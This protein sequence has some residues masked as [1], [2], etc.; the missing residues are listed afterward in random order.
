MTEHKRTLLAILAHPD[1][2]SF[3]MGATIAK[4]A[5]EGVAVHYLC[6]T[7]GASGTV[8]A[9]FLEKFDSIA[10]LRHHE[11]QC[12]AQELG[13][14]SVIMGGYRD[15]GMPGTEANA[16][17]DALINQPLDDVAAHFASE[18]RRLRPDV[19]VTHDPI[20]GY[21][22]PDHIACNKATLRAFEIVN[23]SDARVPGDLPPFQPKKLY[24]STISKTW[25]KFGITV[26]RLLGKDP[27]KFGRNGDIDILDL[28]ESGDFP[29]HAFIKS[30]PFAAQQEAAS[31]CHASQL[32]SGIPRKGPIALF[33][34]LMRGTSD[35]YMRAIPEAQNGLRENDFFEGI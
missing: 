2:E 9:P 31:L 8:D 34:R 1:D 22:H 19:V 6:A 25:M 17:P 27:R 5:A 21:K 4:Y 12:A 11:L 26:M 7:D 13:L 14:T 29:A 15:S 20:G 3:G 18:M 24:Y 33:F 32:A 30:K 35:S 16:H 23:D 28:V 10:D